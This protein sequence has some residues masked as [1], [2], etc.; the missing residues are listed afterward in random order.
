MDR[1]DE[2]FPNLEV[3][4]STGAG[5]DQFEITDIPPNIHLV[6]LIDPAIVDGMREYVTM[7]ALLLQRQMIDY[8]WAKSRGCWQPLAPNMA[9]DVTVGIM[10]FGVLGQAVLGALK[11]LGFRLRAWSRSL[12]D[13]DGVDCFAGANRLHDFA[14][15]CNIVVCLLPLTDATRGILDRRLFDAMPRGASLINVGRGGHLRENDLLA[16]LEDAQLSGAVLDVFDEEPLP[17]DHPF[18]THERVVLTPH[19]ASTTGHESGAAAL[20]ENIRRHQRGESMIG[21]VDRESGY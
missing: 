3:L 19:V 2:R 15:G 12:H 6:R 13:D 8:L 16:A 9:A 7:A 21:L 4:F 18:W 20:I 17:A 10:G 14:S 11:P 1:M 5:V